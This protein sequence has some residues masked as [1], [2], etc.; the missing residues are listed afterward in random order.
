MQVIKLSFPDEATALQVS[1][2]LNVSLDEL[3]NPS[4]DGYIP[5]MPPLWETP[6]YYNALKWTVMDPTG[7]TDPETGAP[8]MAPRP[9]FHI[10]AR[11]LIDNTPHF[12]PE[13]LAFVRPDDDDW[14]IVWG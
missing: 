13:L 9:G 5:P 6:I 11:L 2:M 1:A 3:G 7:E 12:P 8:V 10:F 14:G 4:A